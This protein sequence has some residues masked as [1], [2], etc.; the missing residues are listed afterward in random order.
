MQNT[1]YEALSLKLKAID[2]DARRSNWIISLFS[3]NK[4]LGYNVQTKLITVKQ[5][6][7]KLDK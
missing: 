1:L 6:D 5:Q 3:K 4:A 2:Y 7:K